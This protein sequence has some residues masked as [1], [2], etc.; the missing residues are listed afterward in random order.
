MNTLY[1]GDNLEILKRH[2]SDESV[3]LIYLDPPFNSNRD[4]NVLFRE[5]SGSES[6]AQIK[7]FGDTWNWAGAS[8]AW[9]DFPT[10]CPVPKV[11][12]LMHGFHNAIGENDVLAYLVMMA[13]RLYHLHRALKPTGS[14]YL[15]CDPT[16][17]SYLRLIL[18]CIFSP[19]NFGNEII[20]KRTNAKGL[21]FTRFAKNHDVIYRFCKTDKNTWNA[22]YAE[23]DPAYVATFY[24][25][26]DEE[27]GRKFR[28]GDLTNPNR[29]RPNLTYEFL[30]V[31]RVWRWTK[32]RMQ[33]AFEDGLV[34][35][36][37]LETYQYS[38]D[39]WM[40]KKELR[41]AMYGRTFRPFN[42]RRKNASAI[43][44]KNRLR[45]WNESSLR[46]AIPEMWFL[47]LF[48]GAEPL[49]SRRRSW[50]AIGLE[51]T[52]RR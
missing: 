49:S 13:P 28:L 7:A 48:A 35:Q 39:I 41:S 12:E 32:V 8:E 6:P 47:I 22:Q 51:S 38:N 26:V 33:K 18:D 25:Y 19:K 52:S 43:R 10:L 24:K 9:D 44:R 30:G 45:S 23:H 16:A 4:Y 50:I 37:H 17:S 21:A 29:N 15:H 46:V 34:I 42:R 27:T 36:T 5:Q 20:W 40:N 31:T 11:I 3:D 2:I 1:F 14:L